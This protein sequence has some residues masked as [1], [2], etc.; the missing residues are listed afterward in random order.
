MPSSTQLRGFD[1]SSFTDNRL[2]GPPVTEKCSVNGEIPGTRN[3]D[4]KVHA[5][6]LEV[7]WFNVMMA[8]GFATGFGAVLVP[9]MLSRWWRWL[10]FHFLDQ[11]WTRVLLLYARAAT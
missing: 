11:M 3:E 8:I 1:A 2:C 5:N 6:G 4:R 9:L 7:D 10:Y